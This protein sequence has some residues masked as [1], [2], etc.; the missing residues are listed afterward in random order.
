MRHLILVLGLLLSGCATWNEALKEV[1]EEQ[2]TT[3]VVKKPEIAF[4]SE[5][6]NKDWE[7]FTIE[8]LEAHG[9]EL[10]DFES[11]KDAETFSFKAKT[12]QERKAFYLM[13]ISLMAWRESSFKPDTK[14]E[15]SGH[16][17]GVTSR[18]LLQISLDSGKSYNKNLKNAQEL[19]DP[20][21]NLET[22]VMILNRWIP[23]DGYIG[24]D[25]KGGAR[26]WSVLREHSKSRPKIIEKMKAL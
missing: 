8:A 22:G 18:G 15:E 11:P 13:L 20:K 3:P 10:L 23:K 6:P 4:K 5:F 2:S 7:R 9:K 24:T 25:K 1:Q 14:Y 26:Y 17:A 12:R 19:H 21:I 16:L